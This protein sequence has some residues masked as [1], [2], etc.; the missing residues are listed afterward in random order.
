[1]YYSIYNG[2]GRFDH[3]LMFTVTQMCEFLKKTLLSSIVSACMSTQYGV[4]MNCRPLQ[5]I[6]RTN[7]V[8]TD[9][10]LHLIASTSH[11]ILPHASTPNNRLRIPLWK[12]RKYGAKSTAYFTA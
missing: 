3:T 8:K 1:M 5:P 6:F 4:N 7:L 10:Q 9:T 2:M 11:A 12:V